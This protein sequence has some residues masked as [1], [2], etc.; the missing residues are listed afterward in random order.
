[1]VDETSR[2]GAHFDNL[3]GEWAR[4]ENDHDKMHP[5]R[6]MCGGV[7]SCPMMREAHDIER[8]LIDLLNDWRKL[9]T[10]SEPHRHRAS[11]HGAIG[12]LLCGQVAS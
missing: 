10:A 2:Y 4:L 3:A 7:G 6:S 5:N 11:C 9:P 1:M 12:E 8:T